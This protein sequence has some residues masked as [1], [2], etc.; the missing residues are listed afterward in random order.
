MVNNTQNPPLVASTSDVGTSIE[1]SGYESY[2]VEVSNFLDDHKYT[3]ILL[4]PEQLRK[5]MG[6]GSLAIQLDMNTKQDFGFNKRV[7]F[8]KGS[9]L[10]RFQV[11]VDQDEEVLERCQ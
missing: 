5:Q 6:N 10:W 2:H 4:F 3:A 7:K 1:T 8:S 11:Q 9:L